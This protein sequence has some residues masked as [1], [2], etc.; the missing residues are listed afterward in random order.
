MPGTKEV[1]SGLFT[2]QAITTKAKGIPQNNIYARLA[3]VYQKK[4]VPI[5]SE[6]TRDE[7]DT[8][9]VIANYTKTQ[10]I[11]LIKKL[12]KSRSCAELLQ[13]VRF[14]RALLGKEP[15]RFFDS[16]SSSVFSSTVTTIKR[17]YNYLDLAEDDF[18]LIKQ[19]LTVFLRK[20]NSNQLNGASRS[21]GI[22]GSLNPHWV[23]YSIL[24]EKLG[25][26]NGQ[27]LTKEEI[28]EVLTATIIEE[29]DKFQH[30]ALK[31]SLNALSDTEIV[32]LFKHK[33]L[34]SHSFQAVFTAIFNSNSL[35]ASGKS[36][37]K[38]QLVKILT[39]QP[40]SFN[41]FYQTFPNELAKL[42]NDELVNILTQQKSAP[43]QIGDYY[44]YYYLEEEFYE[45]LVLINEKDPQFFT[46]LSPKSLVKILCRLEFS[47]LPSD[48]AKNRRS[49]A[50]FTIIQDSMGLLTDEFWLK[51][52]LRADSTMIE[53]ILSSPLAE[54]LT[55][56][57]S[58]LSKPKL[59][60]LFTE[61]RVN[62][63]SQ[64]FALVISSKTLN[65]IYPHFELSL[66]EAS[67]KAKLIIVLAGNLTEQNYT[68]II[69]LLSTREN[70]SVDDLSFI[71]TKLNKNDERSIQ[72]LKKLFANYYSIFDRPNL[73]KLCQENSQ[74]AML[75]FTHEV[76]A[77]KQHVFDKLEIVDFAEIAVKSSH[78]SDIQ[79]LLGVGLVKK[80][81]Q[82]P[83][84]PVGGVIA[85][86]VSR[87]LS[88]ILRQRNAATDVG[89]F[90][91]IYNNREVH[92]LSYI[93]TEHLV[94]SF[95][96]QLI[97]DDARLK[98]YLSRLFV[99]SATGKLKQDDLFQIFLDAQKNGYV[100]PVAILNLLIIGVFRRI[101]VDHEGEKNFIFQLHTFLS[102]KLLRV[103][104]EQQIQ[105][106]Y[107]SFILEAY[108]LSSVVREYRNHL[109]TILNY[110]GLSTDNFIT[111][112]IA[113]QANHPY[114]PIFLSN[115]NI[116]SLLKPGDV[117]Q[118]F[119]IIEKEKFFLPT[120]VK[121]QLVTQLLRKNTDLSRELSFFAHNARRT[122][123][124]DPED[125][126]LLEKRSKKSKRQNVDDISLVSDIE[127]SEINKLSVDQIQLEKAETQLLI[128]IHQQVYQTNNNKHFQLINCLTENSLGRLVKYQNRHR[129]LIELF[130]DH[131][132]LAKLT[133]EIAQKLLIANPLLPSFISQKLFNHM[134]R[135]DTAPAFKNAIVTLVDQVFFGGGNARAR[136]AFL[137]AA[138]RYACADRNLAKFPGLI[139]YFNEHPDAIAGIFL[140][141]VNHA[142]VNFDSAN[143]LRLVQTPQIMAIL[144]A[145][146]NQDH[147]ESTFF[148]TVN[149]QL[150][151]SSQILITTALFPSLT[152]ENIVQ[153]FLKAQTRKIDFNN[154]IKRMLVEKLD[155]RNLHQL[156]SQVK[157]NV[158]DHAMK[159]ALLDICTTQIQ[160]QK[161]FS[162][163]AFILSALYGVIYY[164]TIGWVLH[165]L[166]PP[167]RPS[168]FYK[169]LRGQFQPVEVARMKQTKF[170]QKSHLAQIA[171]EQLA[172]K[173]ENILVEVQDTPV[174]NRNVTLDLFDADT[175]EISPLLHQ[176]TGY[177]YLFPGEKKRLNLK[178]EAI[179]TE[180]DLQK[181]QGA[182]FWQPKDKR[183]Y[184]IDENEHSL[185]LPASKKQELNNAV[186]RSEADSGLYYG[187]MAKL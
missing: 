89:I 85:Q 97:T 87:A 175:G 102:K 161:D 133:P 36:L 82:L 96:H 143:L 158:D 25:E 150:N 26:D 5:L 138:F 90:N 44:N 164:P 67:Q 18:N 8:W 182:V 144:A 59:Q 35:H 63:Y 117:A 154:Q 34:S 136:S 37:E 52:L 69:E 110:L 111:F 176:S 30:R 39:Y 137:L 78:Q 168:C 187:T 100:L 86:E 41:Y 91:F 15:Y 166:A 116:I 129:Q 103:D 139:D 49:E 31:N 70:F 10:A 4:L 120:A 122:I 112:L 23:P 114:L 65:L 123:L 173:Q 28:L 77:V 71:V 153:I 157:N 74:V 109:T 51:L 76:S 108:R 64:Y 17:D 172:V 146:K 80:V 149:S 105:Q 81:S 16:S 58:R 170:E 178:A 148:N 107:C 11:Q 145:K 88:C 46:T 131:L 183:K 163:P 106:A 186:K 165:F 42:T 135:V 56:I 104:S 14:Q 101:G 167:T 6:C 184:V 40:E 7:T 95:S 61:K 2:E 181:A 177:F 27:S 72:L 113:N 141:G 118:I 62:S 134:V 156:I 45:T 162:I 125:E 29:P 121:Q 50:V 98:L 21:I 124:L 160:R 19:P 43:Y 12:S 38:P 94:I 24:F 68:R 84:H 132:L 57:I 128:E 180:I 140:Y 127:Q 147:L 171:D 60:E 79:K 126:L 159:L 33:K 55:D 22:Q 32:E 66:L 142:E 73:L 115:S 53:R 20:N 152:Q 179:E 151:V 155:F 130:K 185:T 54:K 174:R 9:D 93:T 1:L 83:P 92:F 48:R 47:A 169:F 3:K 119:W 13:I 75:L 99:P